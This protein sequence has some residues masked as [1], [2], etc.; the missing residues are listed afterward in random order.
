MGDDNCRKEG[1]FGLEGFA[2]LAVLRTRCLK[3]VVLDL[4]NK[5][6]MTD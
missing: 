3:L 1:V 4:G 2:D 6:I 5:R